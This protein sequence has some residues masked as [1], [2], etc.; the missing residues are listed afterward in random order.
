MYILTA[1][2]FGVVPNFGISPTSKKLVDG[3]YF[4]KDLR[5]A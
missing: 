3:V 1:L 5:K 2:Q 4:Y